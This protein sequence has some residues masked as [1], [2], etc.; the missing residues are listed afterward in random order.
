MTVVPAAK[1]LYL[2]DGHAQ[3][4]RAYHALRPGMT[5]PVTREP[6]NLTFGF[7]G[8]LLKL[9]R[10]YRPDYLAV[11]VDVGGDQESFRSA[12]Y[13]QYKANRRETPE[14]FHPQVERCLQVLEAMGV[15]VIGRGGVEA[16][17]VIASLVRRLEREHPDLKIRIVSRD[18]DL[19]QLIDERVEL[20]D[21]YKDETVTPSGIFETDGVAPGQVRDILALMGDTTD[22]V[23]GVPGI[24][25][26][27]AAQLI[28]KYGSLE[29][30]LARLEEVPGKRRESLEA[31]RPTIGLARDLVTLREDLD[32]GLDLERARLDPG[33]IPVGKV[34][35]IFRELGFTGRQRELADL[36]GDAPAAA[37]AA[38]APRA[39]RA[40]DGQQDLFAE[41]AAVAVLAPSGDYRMIATAEALE[42]LVRDL[43]AAGTFAIDTETDG[44]SPVS[45]NLC[46]VSL[47]P[48]RGAGYYVPLRSPEPGSHLDAE[49]A[50]AILRPVLE[51]PALRKVGHNLKFDLNVLRRHGVRL[52]GIDFDTMIASYVL[53]ASRSSHRLDVLALAFLEHTCI[54]F[55][56]LVGSGRAQKTFDQVPL[57]LAVPYAAEDADMALRLRDELGPRLD[58]DGLRGLFDEVEMP[59]VEVL[60]ELEW[61]GIRIDPRELDRQRERL[62]GRIEELR[63]RIAGAAPHPF[64]PDSPKQLAAVLYRRPDQDPPG[65]GLRAAR[66]GKT[67]PSTDQEV[68]ERL[69][70]D[71][72]IA[73]PLPGL[74]VEYRQLTKLVSTYLVA[75]KDAIDPGTG[76]VH[77]SFNQTVAATGR[78]SS[79]DPNLQNIPIRTDVGREIR[80][81]F[82]AD[83]GNAL[84]AAD[85]SQIELRML[86]HLSGDE[87]LIAAFR[88][89]E[90][91]HVSVAAQV[92]GVEPSG[93]T[94]AQRD[95]AKMVN[96]GIIYGITAFGLARRLGPE[97]S[98]E[99]AARFIADYK[100]RYPRI[101]EFLDRC[102]E[103]ART[104]GWVET[105]LGR[106]R[107]IP[108]ASERDAG[109][110]ALGE[111]MAINSVVQGSAADLI[112]LAMIQLHRELPERFPKAR[113][114]LQIHDELVFEGPRE[115]AEALRGFVAGRM[116]RAMD[117]RVP[118]KVGSA[119]STVWIDVK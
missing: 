100:A 40:P 15:P 65:L 84:V 80:R 85:Y 106:R 44:L 37:P 49:R 42:D 71:P 111:R 93:V 18:K 97:V 104:R 59:L 62:A 96:F 9:I 19:A 56:S 29:G 99:Q 61:N 50:L 47:S 36:A 2:I 27:T 58:R 24:G 88:R 107:P 89:G 64:N 41:P 105:I 110:R 66:R 81:A 16:D 57:E 6:T 17:D 3:F 45:A 116:E 43:R 118:L 115:E 53:D 52:A 25:P 7:T 102:V 21:I 60:A 35:A 113:M 63:R 92:F 14:D 77:A 55:S 69:A 13:P 68:L 48:G 75:L 22:N 5:S 67:G 8:I 103:Q 114:L 119:W 20:L 109:R 78:L 32:V 26:R 108:Q 76:R 23:P 82:V 79:S 10:E 28:L 12:L 91:I 86:A 38:A 46:G 30:L 72:A 101:N 90:D 33:R 31:A 83:P 95:A 117:L 70:G 34:A 94:P 98:R 1:T 73:S 4:F 87:G 74:I 54:P 39:A 51:D 11:V 112:K